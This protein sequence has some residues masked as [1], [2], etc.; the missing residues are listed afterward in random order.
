MA[1]LEPRLRCVSTPGCV[2][3]TMAA[4][5]TCRELLACAVHGP[6][7]AA[8][9]WG[10]HRVRA[11]PSLWSVQW[12]LGAE[13]GELLPG[14]WAPLEGLRRAGCASAGLV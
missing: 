13:K 10:W 11:E 2:G 14:P 7:G 1:W 6:R 4:D 8:C 5:E 9:P 3:V 12:L